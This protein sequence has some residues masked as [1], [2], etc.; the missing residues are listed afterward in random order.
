MA[1]LCVNDNPPSLLRAPKREK[2]R[3]SEA[4]QFTLFQL[5]SA[6]SGQLVGLMFGLRQAKPAE[7]TKCLLARYTESRLY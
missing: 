2:P 5:L 4:F 7:Q 1:Q 6:L 3:I